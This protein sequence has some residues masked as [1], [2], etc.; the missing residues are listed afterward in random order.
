MKVNGEGPGRR[1]TLKE[2]AAEVGVSPATVS[3]A[4]NRPDQLSGGLRERVF[5]AARRLGYPGPDPMARGLKRG[6]AGAVGVLYADRLSYAFA[7]PAA[8]LFLRGLSE[9]TEEAGLGLS[10]ISG[11]SRGEA[12]RDAAVDGFVV[13]CMAE[14]DP[15]VD[16]ALERRL[17]AVFV[18]QTPRRGAPAVGIRDED[19]ARA[20]A[21]HLLGL[22]HRRLGVVSLE[23]A[24]DSGGG[25]VEGERRAAYLP[26]RARLAGYA[27]AY[28]SAGLPR[29]RVPVHECAENSVEWGR[30]AA[31]ALLA[32]VPG[33][34]ALLAMS[35]MLA[36]GAVEAAREAGLAVPGDLSVVGFDDVPEAARS[37][38]PLTTVR[39]PHRE[40]G[41][42]AG[43]TLIARLGNEGPREEP[44][45]LPTELVVRG[46]TAPPARGPR[47]ESSTRG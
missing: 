13:F 20:A 32:R 17:P 24:R 42:L 28:E 23:F 38:P 16:A 11:A 9:A 44:D 41:L 40:K 33:P 46:S 3:N 37:T 22:G 25:P 18:D 21:E 31:E 26:T 45:P 10:L 27:A 5:E 47:A 6:R 34:T 4:Y 43:R 7:D 19:G 39:Q 15:L 30:A 2:V 1:A 8:V 14:D 36:F 12:V 29:G 35:D